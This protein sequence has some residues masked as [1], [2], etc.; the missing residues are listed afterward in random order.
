MSPR[1]EKTKDRIVAFARGESGSTIAAVMWLPIFIFVLGLVVD[2]ATIFAGEARVLQVVQDANRALATGRISTTSDA[3]TMILSGIS[4]LA[5]NATVSTQISYGLITSTVSVPL[6][7]IAATGI[8]A[9]FD[10]TNLKV[11]GQMMDEG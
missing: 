9:V 6:S 10:G 5:P 7:D 4:T 1:I 2:T 3:Q 8:V 11:V